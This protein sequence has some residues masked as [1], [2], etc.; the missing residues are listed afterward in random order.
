MCVCSLN[1]VSFCS[2]VFPNLSTANIYC[3][4]GKHNNKEKI[5]EYLWGTHDSIESHKAISGRTEVYL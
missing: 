1:Y 3:L 5:I 4:C 2:S